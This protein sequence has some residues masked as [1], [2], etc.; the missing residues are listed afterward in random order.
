M[1]DSCKEGDAS[2]DNQ[3]DW[4]WA[5]FNKICL[6]FEESFKSK[7]NWLLYRHTYIRRSVKSEKQKIRSAKENIWKAIIEFCFEQ[8]VFNFD[9]HDKLNKISLPDISKQSQIRCTHWEAKANIQWSSSVAVSS[10]S[11]CFER[12]PKI[13]IF[14]HKLQQWQE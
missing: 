9:L 2:L 4:I 6:G 5:F 13:I 8:K 3:E 10:K 12:H 11:I 1:E 14:F 7:G